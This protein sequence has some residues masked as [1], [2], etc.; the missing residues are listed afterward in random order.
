[1]EAVRAGTK[2]APV[3]CFHM[4]LATCC[5]RLA[6]NTIKTLREPVSSQLEK[7][8]KPSKSLDGGTRLP[9]V[10]C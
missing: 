5:A 8:P 7:L 3:A 6:A 10:C 4:P 1:M 2:P 9:G